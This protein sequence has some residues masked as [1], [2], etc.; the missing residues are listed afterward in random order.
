[1][2]TLSASTLASAATWGDSAATRVASYTLKR[3]VGVNPFAILVTASRKVNYFHMMGSRGA[4][5]A[6][7]NLRIR[8]FYILANIMKPGRRSCYRRK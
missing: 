7:W 2:A 6:A 1:M 5:L 3:G 4:S 8:H